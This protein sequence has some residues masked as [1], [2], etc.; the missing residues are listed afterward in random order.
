[1][2]K[3]LKEKQLDWTIT[4][5]P[6]ILITGLCVLFFI[7]PNKSNEILSKIRFILG[8]TL[9]TYY[10]ILGLGIFLFSLYIS[11]SKY[12]NIVLGNP[13]EYLGFSLGFPKTIF[14]YLIQNTEILF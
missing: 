14:P 13:N 2:N 7:A 6:L 3:E 5:L 4:L 11:Y 9:G 12:G 8:D 10:L 1:M